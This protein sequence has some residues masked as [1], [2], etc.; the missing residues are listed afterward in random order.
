MKV[1][2]S[3]VMDVPAEQIALSTSVDRLSRA[4]L[5]CCRSADRQII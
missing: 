5:S 1:K 2:T 3:L 4:G